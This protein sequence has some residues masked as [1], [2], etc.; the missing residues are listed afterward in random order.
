MRRLTDDI[1]SVLILH[2]VQQRRLSLFIKRCQGG[3][4]FLSLGVTAM[5]YT[6][7]NDVAG[8]LVLREGY[9]LRRDERDDFDSVLWIPMLNDMLRNIIA[10][11]VDDEAWR[12]CMKLL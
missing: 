4:D 2:Q 7:L 10:V 9:E 5:L 6:L 8:K 3:D 12:A 11:L 1:V